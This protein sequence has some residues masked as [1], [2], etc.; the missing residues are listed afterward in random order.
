MCCRIDMHHV[1]KDALLAPAHRLS[2]P[3]FD[4]SGQG[5]PLVFVPSASVMQTH[6]LPNPFSSCQLCASPTR[7]L[8]SPHHQCTFELL[9][10]SF[11]GR[12]KV[13]WC[14]PGSELRLPHLQI[15]LSSYHPP[16]SCHTLPPHS[17]SHSPC[18]N[19]QYPT[20]H[21]L[22]CSVSKLAGPCFLAGDCASP[23]CT[24]TESIIPSI[25]TTAAEADSPSRSCSSTRRRELATT[26]SG[27][28]QSHHQVM[29][30]Y[31]YMLV[32]RMCLA[33]L[34]TSGTVY[35]FGCFCTG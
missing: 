10:G 34:S 8:P 19:N 5:L 25:A 20:R 26:S 29:A 6:P 9:P 32:C 14:T 1:H 16:R 22:Y 15:P 3:R 33:V 17:P 35:P 7:H 4:V 24:F 2:C 23:A 21:L 12:Q 31:F 27:I 30:H 11:L 18:S 13:V 28:P